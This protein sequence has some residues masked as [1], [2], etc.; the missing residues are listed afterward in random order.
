[1]SWLEDFFSGDTGVDPGVD[2]GY[3]IDNPDYGPV[4]PA[5]DPGW[6]IDNPVIP[7]TPNPD[8]YRNEGRN[9][10]TPDSTQT[11]GS[12]WGNVPNPGDTSGTGVPSWLSRLVN[13]LQTPAG[14]LTGL[15]GLAMLY[16]IFGK[17]GAGQDL[18]WKGKINLGMKANRSQLPQ[19][20]TTRVPGSAG[21]RYFTDTTYAAQGGL[22][23]LAGGRYLAGPTDGMA[24]QIPSNID[25]GQEAALSHG[26]FV[27]PADVVS[28]L[29]NG[30]SDAGADVLYKMMERV[31]QQRTGKKTQARKINPEKMLGGGIAGYSGGGAV[32]F[33]AGDVVPPAGTTVSSNL[34]NWAGDYIGDY[35]SRGAALA[36]TP[37]EAYTGPLTAGP[38]ALQTQAWD[39]LS[40]GANTYTP[41]SYGN[42]FAAPGAYSAGSF[43]AGYK[44]LAA[45]QTGTFDTQLGP[46]GSV[47]SYMS[48]YA[49]NVT[50]IASRD[51]ARSA[52]IQRMSDAGRLAQAG[53]YGGSRQAVMEAEGNKNLGQLQNDI[54]TKGLQSAYDRA[55]AQRL[56]ESGLGL[57]AQGMGEASR[58]FGYGQGMNA[59]D[60]AAG[61]GLQAQGMGE[62]SRQFG[63]NQ[64]LQ[65]ALGSAQYGLGA[66]QLNSQNQQ[67]GANLGLQNLM[68]M[69][70]AGNTQRDITQQ[71]ITA[72]RAQW[73]LEQ[74]D[75]FKK[76]EWQRSLL[77]GLPVGTTTSAANPG[78]TSSQ[79]SDSIGALIKLYPN[80]AQIF[81]EPTNPPGP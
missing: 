46:V 2:P 78:S 15:A 48:P 36:N 35:L 72:D 62:A 54:T 24:D 27:V 58:Q 63:A 42:T 22:M 49:E 10:P 57:Q 45:Y 74:A 21:R 55:M 64:A 19:D 44:P 26:E 8:N 3:A 16:D 71:G 17:K 77:G 9:Y 47:Q 12:I 33:A 37:Y 75:P 68:M 51:A 59:A 23:G 25:G 52:G 66:N 38:S 50:D 31:R 1:M 53:A 7:D 32:A 41:T 30:N 18:G 14:G 81:G 56:A 5:P 6:E 61:Y 73:D 70:N 80:L 40:S 28:H 20:N 79:L 65:A 60:K 34:S 67:F 76:V 39:T 29:G 4:T 13:G 69:M 43:D 11:P